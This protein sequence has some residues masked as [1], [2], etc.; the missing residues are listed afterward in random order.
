ME[1]VANEEFHNLYSSPN[2]IRQINRGRM[3]WVGHVTRI[4]E[5]RTVY[6]VLVG[7]PKERRPL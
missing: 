3:K 7:K 2:I 6:K 5:E 4:G 1:E